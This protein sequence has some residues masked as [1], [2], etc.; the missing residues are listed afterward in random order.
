LNSLQRAQHQGWV[1]QQ[2]VGLRAKAFSIYV[3]FQRG[4]PGQNCKIT[5]PFYNQLTG[6]CC[7][8][9][10]FFLLFLEQLLQQQH[11][12][13]HGRKRSKTLKYIYVRSIA[14]IFI[15]FL[16]FPPAFIFIIFQLF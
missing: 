8:F 4:T 6:Q 3:A 15:Q 14:F 16:R 12:R 5:F 7:R 1:S 11:R 9:F 13:Q 10:F 2:H